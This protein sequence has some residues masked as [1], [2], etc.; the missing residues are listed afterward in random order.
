MTVALVFPN[1][2]FENPPVLKANEIVLV[3]DSLFFNQFNF[4][5]QKL[6]L[7][8]ASMLF[9]RQYLE[10]QGCAVSSVVVH[11]KQNELETFFSTTTAQTIWCYQPN[12]YLLERRLKRFEEK[13]NKTIEWLENPNYLENDESILKEL[14]K[15][16]KL[17]MATFYKRQRERLNV[18]LDASGNPVGGKWSFDAENRKKMPLTVTPPYE[19]QFSEN[20]HVKQAKEWVSSNYSENFGSVQSFNYPIT[21]ADA[22]AQLQ[23]FL[24]VQF[25]LFGA[26]EDAFD[27]HVTRGFHSVLTP[28]LNIGLISPRYIVEKTLEYAEQ[29]SIELNNVEGF[30]RQVIGWREFMRGVYLLVGTK[31]RLSNFWNF[32]QAMPEAFYTAKTGIPPVDDAI[33]KTQ[34]Y[35][36]THHIE[37]LMV[38]GNFMLLCEIHPTAVYKWFMETYI[39]AYDWVMVPNVYGMSQYADGGLITTKPYLSG[40]NYIRKMSHYKAGEW[41]EIW[42]ALYWRFIYKNKAIFKSNYRM[43][44]MAN[45]VDK[46]P[47]NKLNHHLTVAEKYLL[48][49]HG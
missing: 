26:Y 49:L 44:M 16:K 14:K 42:D 35:A 30:I 36:Y 32:Q 2:L 29:N 5:K 6:V 18:L 39:D 33:L 1:Q 28:A 4:H 43:S 13:Y 15:S 27:K 10:N 37:R 23:H 11:P 8:K 7:H 38:L 12:D 9:Y 22:K 21:F 20:E 3:E 47:E 34:Q 45:L 17:F 31:Q 25:P 40:S 41:C 48:Q 19:L 46:M 24:E